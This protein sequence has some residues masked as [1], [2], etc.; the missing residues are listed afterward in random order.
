VAKRRRG[1]GEGGV[2]HAEN[3]GVSPGPRTQARACGRIPGRLYLVQRAGGFSPGD[4]RQQPAINF[5]V[6]GNTDIDAFYE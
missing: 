3:A 5:I 6:S 2:T 4:Q 1:D